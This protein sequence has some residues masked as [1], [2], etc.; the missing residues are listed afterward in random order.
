MLFIQMAN[1]KK[2]GEITSCKFRLEEVVRYF[3]HLVENR[4]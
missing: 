4:R 1:K 2:R 3:F